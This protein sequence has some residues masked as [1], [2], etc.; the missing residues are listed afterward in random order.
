MEAVVVEAVMVL[1]A[2]E[3]IVVLLFLTPPV[4]SLPPTLTLS[5]Q[6]G[7]VSEDALCVKWVPM[8]PILLA[9]PGRLVFTCTTCRLANVCKPCA[10]R[11]HGCVSL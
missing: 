2:M 4:P 1:V 3:L 11:C 9:L 5:P 8:D 6:C 7:S 10:V